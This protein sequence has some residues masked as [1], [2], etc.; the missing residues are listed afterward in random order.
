MTIERAL[1]QI[2]PNIWRLIA[3]NPSVMTGPGTNTY[4][5]GQ[6][7]VV[8]ID[9]GPV[10]QT[11]QDN[12]VAAIAELGAEVESII[13]TH[14]HPD[15]DSGVQGLA[16]RLQVPILRFNTPLRHDEE[17]TIDGVSLTVKHTPGH[18]H[19]HVC[20]WMAEQRVL[21]GADLVAGEGTILI[22]PPDGDM[23][24]YL[25]SLQAMKAL[26]P[27]L[28][29][30]GHGPVIEDPA[31]LLQE[32]TDHRL[33]REQQV[34]SY[35]EQG[36]REANAIAAQIYAGQPPQVLAIAAMQVTAHLTK[37]R[38]EGRI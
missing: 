17:I 32:Y 29:L 28:I 24:D 13:I 18:I 15:H 7:R 30:P 14:P 6:K 25:R 3:P 8:I 33:Q 22:I 12:T 10:N 35:F 26:E 1:T 9:S 37:L 27:A 23:A 2:Q 36:H 31:G 38:N 20:L 34:L 4:I 5:V 11:H 16:Q 21:F 19:A